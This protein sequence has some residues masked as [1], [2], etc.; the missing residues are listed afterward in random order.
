MTHG[1]RSLFRANRM[2]EPLTFRYIPDKALHFV[3]GSPAP[4]VPSVSDMTDDITLV[5]ADEAK[6]FLKGCLSN[7]KAL[8]VLILGTQCQ[9]PSFTCDLSS[10]GFGCAKCL[11]S[12]TY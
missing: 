4:F 5:D 3:D 9:L 2:S 8:G 12:S 6:D 7:L 1:N 10:G 11:S